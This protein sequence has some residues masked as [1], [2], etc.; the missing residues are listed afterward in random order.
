M[1]LLEKLNPKNTVS[2]SRP[3]AHALG[4]NAAVV[5]SALISKQVYYSRREM[6]D[7]DGYFYSTVAD[8]QESTTLTKRQQSAAVK[9]LAAAGLIEHKVCGMPARRYFRVCEEPEQ[10][11][12]LLQEG[13][14]VMSELNPISQKRVDNVPES[15][16]KTVPQE[17]TKCENKR[18]QNVTVIYNPNINK[19]KEMNPNQSIHHGVMDEMEA[20]AERSEYLE[21]IRENIGYEGFR[22]KQGVDE[23][24]GIMLDVI[25]SNKQFIR[26]NSED[27]PKEAVKSRFLKLGP[28]HIEYVMSALDKNTSSVKNIRAYLTTALYNAPTTLAGYYTALVNHD[29][30]GR[31]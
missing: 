24:V 15:G 13:E 8:L 1:E 14:A 27:I 23:L 30:Y 10:L 20:N 19:S 22:E 29:M 25:C 17:L 9:A 21:L 26:V 2:F 28:E 31:K 11:N 4:I 5:Y 3:I 7:S 18:E 12:K 6:L 16:D